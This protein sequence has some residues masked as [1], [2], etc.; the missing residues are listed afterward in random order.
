MI[1][2]LIATLGLRVD[3]RP[4]R[5]GERALDDL[6]RSGERTERQSDRTSAAM[7]RMAKM[8]A[9][10]AA[11]LSVRE[12]IEAQRRYD[13]LTSSLITATGSTENAAEAFKALQQFAASTPYGLAEVTQAFIK[14]RNMGLDP[15]EAAL[16]S[17]GNTAAAMGKSLNDMVEA[18]ADAATGEFERLKEF[19]IKTK[20]EGDKLAFTFQGTTTRIANNAG[21]IEDYLQKLGNVNFAGGMELR[22]KTLDGAIA[23]LADTWEMALVKISQTGGEDIAKIAVM[24]LTGALTDLISIL[25]AVGKSADS[26]E[27]KM[28]KVSLVNKALTTVFE[29]VAV[30]GVN[31]A[32]VFTQVGNELGGLAAQAAAVARMDFAG[33]K[34]IGEMMKVDAEA[35]R[36]AVDAKTKA[37]LE[38]SEK[39]RAASEAEAAALK[40]SGEDRLAKY[41]IEREAAAQSA[42]DAKKRE[43]AI[44]DAQKFIVALQQER[45]ELGLTE[46]QQRMLTAARAAM[47][48]PTEELRRKIMEEAVATDTATVAWGKNEEARKAAEEAAKAY[49]GDTADIWKQVE[50]INAQMDAYGKSAKAAI[51]AEIEK[52]KGILAAR[53]LGEDLSEKDRLDMEERISALTILGEKQQALRDMK[54]NTEG[55]QKLLDVMEALSDASQDAATSMA[56]AFGRVGES[57]GGLITSMATYERSQAAIAKQLAVSLDKAKE[58]DDPKAAAKARADAAMEGARAQAKAYGDMAKAGKGFFKEHTAGY[59]AMEG[60]EKA[61]RAYEVALAMKSM[62]EKS[63]ILQMFTSLFIGSKAAETAATQASVGPDVAA[64]MAKG[65]AAAAAGVAV[66]AQGDPY[67][68]WGRMA[69]MAAAMAALGFAVSGGSK[70]DTTAK[71]RQ[72]ATGTGSIMGDSSAKS[73][74]IARAIELSASNSNIELN[75]TQGMLRALLSIESAMAGVGGILAQNGVDGKVG[76]AE[77]DSVA[78][79]SAKLDGAGGLLG[80][81]AKQISNF[82]MGGKVTQI[83]TGLMVNRGTA[84]ALA[85]GGVQAS[86]YLD[87]KKDGGLFRSDKYRT[88]TRA[89]DAEASGQLSAVI[90]NMV[91]AIG[92][93]GKLLGLGGDAFTQ[94]L[95]AFVV[96]IGKISTKDLKPEEIQKQLEA[97]FSKVGDDMARWAVDGLTQLQ[98]VGEGALET[99][100]RVAANY[101][102][103]D[104]AL[105]SIGMSFGATGLSSV[106]AREKLIDLAGGI[107]ELASQASSFAD[108]FMTEAERLAPVQKYVAEQMAA[109]GLSFI[110]SREGFKQYVL[111][112]DL[113]NE[114]Q[115]SQYVRLMDLQ[116]AFAKVTA[117]TKDAS[118]SQQAI[119]DERAELQDELDQ[120]TMTAT[121]LEAKRR[122]ALD[123]SNRALF[124]QVRAAEKAKE[125]NDALRESMGRQ[126]D[127]FK[128]AAD[129]LRSYGANLMTGNL[130]TLNPVEQLAEA[131]AQY[132]A[133]AEKALAGDEKALSQFQ[134]AADKFLQLSQQVNGGDSRYSADYAGVLDMVEKLAK[135]SDSRVDSAQ[136]QIDALD[137]VTASVTNLADLLRE[138]Y[139]GGM[140]ANAAPSAESGA[141]VAALE[142]MRAEQK[143]RDEATQKL[144][145]DAAN[146]QRTATVESGNKVV[147]AVSTPPRRASLSD[148][149]AT[150][151]R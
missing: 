73:E 23:N 49:T 142:A 19:G 144:M 115:A 69:A 65:Q 109:L 119:A 38:A 70:K 128:G 105:A 46:S 5:E 139:A 122:N 118:K 134:G 14:M 37:I 72:A 74:S 132:S 135:Y 98:K 9:S 67:T 44:Q 104:S 101:A 131:Q 32:Y 15:S 13:K 63:G 61:F 39:G 26:N 12:I 103:L 10:V 43:K 77:F 24:G 113:A 90:R 80:K 78:N 50:A 16:R 85:A 68:A 89:L 30:L 82:V 83:D 59:R 106:A 91:S 117:A 22:A 107:D 133:I 93:A 48:A 138:Q 20:T 126:I 57:L 62:L 79:L 54:V 102:N 33:A 136:A 123:A 129:S 143:A 121:Q 64:S 6:T 75:Y 130:S 35:A 11:A 45:E 125:A 92:E 47:V 124:D 86:Q 147:E 56:S 81:W 71:D 145:I 41:K 4:V 21:A 31:V 51:E 140:T 111:G 2:G 99:L 120:L 88:E 52:H 53:L 149:Y 96:D 3:A 100:V 110:T 7:Q 127:T 40:K 116:E 108:N 1:S 112:L 151:D 60:A 87:T 76:E 8:A 42:Q 18:V 148:S 25:G 150:L 114:A 146:L 141:V 95:N 97:A 55:P 34:R 17:Y 66:Q 36:K 58:D 94:R 29:T 27:E 28:G 137:R 84:G